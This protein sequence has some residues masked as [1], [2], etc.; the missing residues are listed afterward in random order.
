MLIAIV[1]WFLWIINMTGIL[2]V[3]AA[4]DFCQL[5]LS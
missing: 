1:P 3:S 5:E 2:I 4:V